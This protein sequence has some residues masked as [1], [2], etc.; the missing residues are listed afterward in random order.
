MMSQLKRTGVAMILLGLMLLIGQMPQADSAESVA[1]D[2]ALVFLSDVVGLDIAKYNVTLKSIVDSPVGSNDDA[3]SVAY[4]LTL[5]G[6]KIDAICQFKNNAVYWCKLYPIIGSPLFTTPSINVIDETRRILNGYQ[7]YSGASYLQE[8]QSMLDSVTEFTS[9]AKTVG[10]V[11]LETNDDGIRQTVKWTNE[12][13]NITNTY[14]YLSISFR[15]GM[16]E[17]FCDRW[18]QYSIG[19]TDVNIDQELAIQIAQKHAMDRIIADVGAENAPSYTFKA[20]QTQSILTMRPRD[21]MLYPKWEILLGLN[22]M[23]QSYGA[24]FRV[25]LWAD[26]GNVTYVGY[27]G[28]YGIISDEDPSPSPVE[29][30]SSTIIQSLSPSPSSSTNPLTASP[31]TEAQ[32]TSLTTVELQTV[33]DGNSPVGTYIAIGAA[34]IAI[35]LVILVLAA[36]RKRS[37]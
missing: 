33:S 11:K 7:S 34:T 8:M 14:N 30:T 5:G 36:L 20:D 27:S 35:A 4:T 21:N 16:F 22:K 2:K 17:F 26:T 32:P 23:V 15:N 12:I 28:S 9:M 10:V 25:F 24:A 31:S 1:S 3:I 18:N 29:S 37:K 13:N 19:N 6:D